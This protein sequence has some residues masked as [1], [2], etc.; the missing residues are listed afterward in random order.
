V[1]IDASTDLFQWVPILTNPSA[2]GSTTNLD[3]NAGNFP[4][5]FYRAI[6]P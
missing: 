3:A 4:E 5:R 6:T 1:E 2:F